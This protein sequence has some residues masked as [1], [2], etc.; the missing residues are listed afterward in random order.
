M[1]LLRGDKNMAY[2]TYKDAAES[3]EAI[4]KGLDAI[5]KSYEPNQK[6]AQQFGELMRTVGNIQRNIQYAQQNAVNRDPTRVASA[7]L[8]AAG[9]QSQIL[10]LQ[11]YVDK[12]QGKFKKTLIAYLTG[13]YILAGKAMKDAR[14]VSQ[15]SVMKPQMGQIWSLYQRGMA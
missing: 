6:Q 12:A 4:G 13:L 2:P 14:D 5:M 9:A 7:G 11:P 1:V 15:T 3:I 10:A 8:N